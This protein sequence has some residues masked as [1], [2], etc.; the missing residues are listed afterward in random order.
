[1]TN[2]AVITN[3]VIKRAHCIISTILLYCSHVTMCVFPFLELL[4]L[5]IN[6]DDIETV[7]LFAFLF[8]NELV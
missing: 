5:N 4:P 6:R 1:M 8:T 3:V 7:A 2:F